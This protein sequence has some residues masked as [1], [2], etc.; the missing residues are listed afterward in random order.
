[1]RFGIIYYK[2]LG[3]KKKDKV[4]WQQTFMVLQEV[5]NGPKKELNKKNFQWQIM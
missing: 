3:T 1:M 4:K 5:L 2:I